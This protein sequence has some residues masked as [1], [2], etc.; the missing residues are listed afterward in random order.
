MGEGTPFYRIHVTLGTRLQMIIRRA[1]GWEIWTAL[2]PTQNKLTHPDN[3]IGTYLFLHDD[4][5]V[6]QCQRHEEGG[7]SNTKVKGPDNE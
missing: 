1:N 4:G 5:S 2:G 7:V 6:T 3:Y